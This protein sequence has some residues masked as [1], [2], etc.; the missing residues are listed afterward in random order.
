MNIE[1]EFEFDENK[2]TAVD[3]TDKIDYFAKAQVTL[4]DCDVNILNATLT[5]KE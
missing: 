5:T 1:I 3:A 2:I 4:D